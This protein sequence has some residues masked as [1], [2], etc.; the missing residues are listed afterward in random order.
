MD[1]QIEVW[2]NPSSVSERA[3][4]N[5]TTWFFA[6]GV[7]GLILWFTDNLDKPL[8]LLVVSTLFGVYFFHQVWKSR[9]YLTSFKSDS[10]NVKIRYRKWDSN[11]V[12]NARL[13]SLRAELKITDSRSFSC[14]LTL[15]VDGLKITVDKFYD[16]TMADMK[17]IFE[18]IRH[19]QGKP[20]TY[21]ERFALRLIERKERKTNPNNA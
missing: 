18:Y 3:F 5:V 17:E 13:E 16:W 12:Y 19:F 6:S 4:Q 14:E 7:F 20:L 15:E 8:I 21:E 9:Y 10:K 1:E 11:H 2:V